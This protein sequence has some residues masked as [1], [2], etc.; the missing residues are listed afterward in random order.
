[1]TDQPT[2]LPNRPRRHAETSFRTVGDEGGLVVIP[3]RAEVKVLNPVAIRVYE[4][5]DGSRTLDEIATAVATEFDVAPDRALEDVRAFVRSL[6]E[7]GMLDE[8]VPAN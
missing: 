5:L 4:M 7:H 2:S 6:A 8:S 1:M 3:G